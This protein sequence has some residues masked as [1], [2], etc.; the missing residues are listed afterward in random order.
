LIVAIA[1][2]AGLHVR[3]I[4]ERIDPTI[5]HSVLPCEANRLKQAIQ[6]HNDCF[7]AHGTGGS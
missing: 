3:Y 5:P 2:F 6:S 4:Y 7:Y 1:S